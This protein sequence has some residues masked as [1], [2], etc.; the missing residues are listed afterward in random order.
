MIHQAKVDVWLLAAVLL[1]FAELLAGAGRWIAG[2]V[3]LVLLMCAYPQSY[4]TLPDGL[5]VRAGVWRMRV[6]YGAI[7]FIGPGPDE[8]SVFVQYG[9]GSQ[10]RIA[11]ADPGAFF[12]DVAAHAPHLAGRGQRLVAAW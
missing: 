2:P 12:E 3:L 10:F 8:G 9:L 11:P 5:L 7:T 6:P 4:V 1:A